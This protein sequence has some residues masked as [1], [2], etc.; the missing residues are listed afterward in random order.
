MKA[1]KRRRNRFWISIA[2]AVVVAFCGAPV[3]A[4]AGQTGAPDAV[5][6]QGV[7]AAEEQ[8]APYVKEGTYHFGRTRAVRQQVE[9]TFV[10]RDDYF[11]ESSYKESPQLAE[12]SIQASLASISWFPSNDSYTV[13]TANNDKNIT[14]MLTDMGF[15]GVE[16]NDYFHLVPKENSSAVAMGHRQILVKGKPYTLLALFS[17]SGA[18]GEEWEGDFTIGSGSMHDGF[19]QARDEALRFMKQYVRKHQIEGDLKVWTAGQSRG[20]AIATMTAGFL[21]DGGVSYLSEKVRLKPEDIYSYGIATPQ[22]I[23]KG[24]TRAEELSVAGPRGGRYAA[25]TQEGGYVSTA[26]GTVDPGAK[27]FSGIHNYSMGTD[28]ITMLPPKVWDYRNYGSMSSMNANGHVTAESMRENLKA[29]CPPIY[30]EYMDRGRME[31]FAT[32]T[33]D[34][35]ELTIKKAPDQKEMDSAQAEAALQRFCEERVVALVAAPGSPKQYAEKGYQDALACAGAMLEIFPSFPPGNMEDML[36]DAALPAALLYFAYGAQQLQAEKRADS[37][38]E[39]IAMALADLTSYLT[40]APLDPASCKI[41][42]FFAAWADFVAENEKSPAVEALRT[43]L[44]DAAPKDLTEAMSSLMGG[45]VPGYTEGDVLPAGDLAVAVLKAC[46]VGPDPASMAAGSYS[47]AESVRNDVYGMAATA[48]QDKVPGIFS[49]LVYPGDGSLADLTEACLPLLL[50]EHD[51]IAQMA[52]AQLAGM[53]ETM[54]ADSL[55]IASKAFDADLYQDCQ[56]MVETLTGNIT[57]FRELASS[58][59]FYTKG[60]AYSAR[61]CVE[62]AATMTAQIWRAIMQH[63]PESYLSWMRADRQ[64][65]ELPLNS[66]KVKASKTSFKVPAKKLKKSK[67]TIKVLKVTGAQGTVSYK[68]VSVNKLSSRFTV[69][70]RTGKVTI[71]K[72]TKKGTYKVKILV[73]ASGDTAHQ[74]GTRTAT[75]K[76]VIK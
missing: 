68:K 6:S 47:D 72:G 27:C 36:P 18:Y 17:R 26:S 67:K 39:A 41:D 22:V 38:S 21:A 58:F 66:M 55:Q 76:I 13:K 8:D 63:Y 75:A 50:G 7:T 11:S 64:Y 4:F 5:R 59:L 52:D 33:L 70:A 32:M 31:D 51:S 45:F 16:S 60:E 34:P 49:I 43:A 48:L 40:G 24:L 65:Y 12:L 3:G 61:G 28:I 10:Y 15:T 53:L 56:K 25:D 37:D 44:N 20:A 71:R 1:T 29:L 9:D 46:A 42:P 35:A 2:T 69:N 57:Q 73:T 19:R 54:T 30:E 23:R 74:A 14:Q 62:T